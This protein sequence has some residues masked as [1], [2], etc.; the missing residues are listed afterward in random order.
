MEINN[1]LGGSF[2]MKNPPNW[3]GSVDC[4]LP[5]A[6]HTGAVNYLKKFFG[7]NDR[8]TRKFQ[9]SSQMQAHDFLDDD[10]EESF[11][12]HIVHT[13]MMLIVEYRSV[14]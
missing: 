7:K 5:T 3:K 6:T 12:P 2:V 4:S 9:Q 10:D 8:D 1:F 14:T 11:V 13:M